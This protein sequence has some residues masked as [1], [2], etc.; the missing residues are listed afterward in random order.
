[1]TSLLFEPIPASRALTFFDNINNVIGIEAEFIRVL[2]IIGIQSLAL[3]HLRLGLGLGL[4][5]APRWG[6]PAGCLSPG[7]VERVE[8]GEVGPKRKQE[9]CALV[10]SLEPTLLKF[11]SSPVLRR[12][13]QPLN[14]LGG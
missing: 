7:P 2:S 1:M 9:H 6:R 11:K 14:F 4:G 10:W 3:W 13:C 12:T 8:A 5:S